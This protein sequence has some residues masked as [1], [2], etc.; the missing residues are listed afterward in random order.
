VSFI[1]VHGRTKDQRSDPVNLDAIR[2]IRQSLSVPV[3][4][5][6][7]VRCLTDVERT[8]AA[9]GCHGVMAARFVLLYLLVHILA[10]TGIRTIRQS[11]NIPVVANGDVR[12]LTDVERTVAATG[13]HGVMAAR[14]VY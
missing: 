10:A 6:G 13:C 4:A 11:L 12:S 5:N 14:F 8:V 9:T 3:V 7:D 1:T 2:T